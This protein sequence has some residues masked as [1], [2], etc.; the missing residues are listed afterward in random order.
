M[1]RSHTPVISV[2]LPFHNAAGTLGRAIASIQQQSFK[3][4]E[5][6]AYDDGSGDASR[7]IAEQATRTDQRVL[8]CGG[9]RVGLVK[10]LQK[11]CREARGAYL[12]RMDA[13]DVS[14]P[15]RLEKQLAF[16]QRNP[17][18]G[19]CGTLV[20]MKGERLA[21]G[22]RRYEAWING[23]I[24]HDDITRELFV[25]CPIAHP[26][27]CMRRDAYEAVGGYQDHGWVED[28]DLLMRF[29]QARYRLGKVPESLLDWYDSPGRLSMA[30]A[31]YDEAAFRALKRH[32]LL[33][34]YLKEHG[35]FH[36]WGA[37][38]VGKRWLREWGNHAPIAAVDI[39]PRK[40][41]KIIHGIPVIAPHEL[42]RPGACF[43]VIAVGT[44]GARDEIRDWL[45]PRGY[46]E[47]R[48]YLFLA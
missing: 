32:Y 18:L 15:A 44:P 42:P 31:R 7:A 37:G 22:R 1:S 27:F 43:V 35:A 14:A 10:A 2:I 38:E 23:L 45:K 6:V 26:T 29:W 9:V 41:G 12:A 48:D 16:L 47:L 5:L 4:W 36:Q 34:T 39:N 21:S 17:E 33:E 11:A 46:Q 3:D 30:D 24:S 40:I 19:L 8:V 25:E 20:T 13:D 28:Y